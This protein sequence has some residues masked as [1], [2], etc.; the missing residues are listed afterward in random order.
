MNQQEDSSDTEARPS[1]RRRTNGED[2]RTDDFNHVIDAGRK[3][4]ILCSP[5]LRLGEGTFTIKYD[6]EMNHGDRFENSHNKAQGQVQEV[7][8]VLGAR[9]SEEMSSESWIAKAVSQ[10]FNECI[11]SL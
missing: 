1:K 4:V 7:M 5:W 8:E 6:P 3:F 11:P 9:L 10:Q 2:E